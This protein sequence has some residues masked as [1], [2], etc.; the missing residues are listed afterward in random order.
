MYACIMV[1]KNVTLSL[2]A[3]ERLKRLKL[4]SESFSSEV[5]RLASSSGSIAEVVGILTEKEADELEKNV[6]EAR[7]SVKVRQW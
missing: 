6:A 4:P 7:K 5:I 3:Y 1:F 2:E